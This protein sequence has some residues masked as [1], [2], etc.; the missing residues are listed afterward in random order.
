MEL[1]LQLVQF[2]LFCLLFLL[3]LSQIQLDSQYIV[4]EKKFQ[5]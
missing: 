3:P 4:D 2:L 5:L 1:E